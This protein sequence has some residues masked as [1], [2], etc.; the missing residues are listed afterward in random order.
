[1]SFEILLRGVGLVP[2]DVAI[3]LHRA[4]SEQISRTILTLAERAPVVFNA[5]QSTHS[6]TAE[7]ML[8]RRRVMASF[9]SRGRSELVFAGLFG[10]QGWTNVSSKVLDADPIQQQLQAQ[11]GKWTFASGGRPERAL[12]D[13]KPLDDLGELIGRLIVADPGARA[14][15]RRAETTV[16]Q[17]VEVS[18]VPRLSP[19]MPAW[20]QLVLTAD[21]VL[22]LPGDWALR[23]AE[24]RGVYLIVDTADGA[25]YVGSA[26]GVENLYGRWRAHVAGEIGI[27]VQLSQRQTRGFRFSILQRVSPDMPVEAVTAIEQS[28]MTRLQT[29]EFGLN[30]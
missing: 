22:D 25:R 20:D 8:K 14:H 16:L 6:A 30:A 24:W 18:P 10:V 12:F 7:A 26:Y 23:L 9:L 13:L 27:T 11:T 1:M 5:Y 4:G 15:M 19:I 2:E 3:C 21:D 17:I 28:W 29:K